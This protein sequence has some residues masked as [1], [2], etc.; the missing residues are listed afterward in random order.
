MIQP[1]LLIGA[2]EETLNATGAAEVCQENRPPDTLVLQEQTQRAAPVHL[3]LSHL[4]LDLQDNILY[5]KLNIIV[6]KGW[7]S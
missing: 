2:M 3:T 1:D 7:S 4:P 6:D 5:N